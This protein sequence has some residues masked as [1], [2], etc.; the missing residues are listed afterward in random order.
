M[1]RNTTNLSLQNFRAPGLRLMYSIFKFVLFFARFLIIQVITII[2]HICT[3][4]ILN[5][6][7]VLL[8]SFFSAPKKPNI[9][10][11]FF[12]GRTSPK[13][14][15]LWLFRYLF[16]WSPIKFFWTSTKYPK[17]K[18]K[19]CVAHGNGNGI[20]SDYCNGPNT[21]RLWYAK[22]FKFMRLLLR[23]CCLLHRP[24]H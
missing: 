15:Y 9:F 19:Y 1:L 2:I 17:N 23:R 24:I 21:D 11:L 22:S 20:D 6:M 13:T 16:F 8:F 18:W 10:Y 12:G 5:F 4:E 3:R 7:S 14:F